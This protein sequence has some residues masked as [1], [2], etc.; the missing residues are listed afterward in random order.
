M[1]EIY[2]RFKARITEGRG[3]TLE[4][5]EGVARGRVWNGRQ[6][7]DCGLIDELGDFEAAV[8]KAKELAGI[9]LDAEIPLLTARPGKNTPW[10]SAA[11][12]AWEQDWRSVQRLLGESALLLMP[13]P[14]VL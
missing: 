13:S 2:Q 10:P 5:V 1:E 3:L 14:M 8:R 12:A 11:P 9:P 7:L 4:A 6:A